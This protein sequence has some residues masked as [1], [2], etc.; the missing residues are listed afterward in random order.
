M[1]DPE[2]SYRWCR[3][4]C[5][6][7]QSTFF[8]SFAI[9][10]RPR[11]NAMYALYAF[12]RIS[13][14]L[15]DGLEAKPGGRSQFPA[16]ANREALLAAW[17]CEL[18]RQLEIESNAEREPSLPNPV[19][20]TL[21]GQFGHLWPGLRDA[22][23]RFEIPKHLLVEIVDGVTMDL[24]YQ[25]PEDW[26]AL[27]DYCYHVASAVGLACTHIWR[28]PKADIPTESAIRCGLGFQLTNILRD[29]KEDAAMG[30]IYLPVALLERYQ[31]DA[32]LWLQGQPTGDWNSM[33]EEVGRLARDYYQ[34]GWQTID[35]LTPNSQRMFSLIWRSYY[36]LLQ[37]VLANKSSLWD[38]ARIR[39]ST[40]HK[41]QLFSQHYW[42]VL[43]RRLS[44]PCLP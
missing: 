6:Q 11:R 7:S 36:A 34:Q 42:N 4:L 9:L 31:V 22:V 5:R 29:V 24:V 26:Q 25:Q 12:S 20:R 44:S 8:S 43:Y 15:S 32:G 37:E 35:S 10:D 23:D 30:R 17:R 33:L 13:D 3:K 2:L 38:G 28:A 39:V 18:H 27:E 19:L 14:D 41:L 1:S 40:S 21:E 16:D